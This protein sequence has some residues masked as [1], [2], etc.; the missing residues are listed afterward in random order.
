M[1]LSFLPN[2]NLVPGIHA[3]TWQEFVAEFGY[4]NHRKNLIDGLKKAMNQLKTCNCKRVYIDGSFVTK[5]LTPGDWD[6]CYDSAEMDLVKLQE[7]YPVFFELRHPRAA[8]I[9]E[10]KGEIFPSSAKADLYGTTFLLFFQ[11]EK[12]HQSPK[13][14]IELSLKDYIL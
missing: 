7:E 4:T 3:I 11:R 1:A 10:F 12:M 9:A 2:G 8:Q 14:N 6:G 13:G 5:K